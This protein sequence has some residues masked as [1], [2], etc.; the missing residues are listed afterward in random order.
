M[1]LFRLSDFTIY[2]NLNFDDA[3][4]IHAALQSLYEKKSLSY[5][6]TLDTK[7][8]P[9]DLTKLLK[10]LNINSTPIKPTYNNH[11]ALYGPIRPVNFPSNFQK[12]YDFT[13]LELFL[14]EL[15]TDSSIAWLM[16]K[17]LDEFRDQNIDQIRLKHLLLNE[18]TT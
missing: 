4:I 10:L 8:S 18:K 16:N 15:I 5:P 13:D 1:Y 7:I 9:S 12:D 17:S 2:L 3:K 6:K 11:L 14:H